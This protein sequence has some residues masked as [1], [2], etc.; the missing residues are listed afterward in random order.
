L[1]AS[2]PPA[3]EPVTRDAAAIEK[4]KYPARLEARLGGR[5]QFERFSGQV[6]DWTDSAMSRVYALRRLAQQFPAEAE[7]AMR[8][9]ERRT[10]QGLAREHAGALSKELRKITNTVNPVL[11][12]L[13]AS[14]AAPAASNAASWQPAGE[15]LFVS[16]RRVETLLAQ[17]LGVSQAG[18]Q[19]SFEDAASQLLT[20]LSQFTNGTEHCLR[21]LSYDDVRQSK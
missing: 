2:N 11:T 7:A 19:A 6:L 15:E 4:P 8:P 16:G 13:G 21:L 18:S 20:A 14:G 9:E 12:S 10:L 5:P 1:P 17:V 3:Q